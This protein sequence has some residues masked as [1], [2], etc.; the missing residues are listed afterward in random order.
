MFPAFATVVTANSDMPD[1]IKGDFEEARSILDSSPRG[2]AALLRLCVQKLCI[3]LG[4]KGKNIDDDIASLV[5][6]GLDP[7]VQQS[8]D[9]VRVI[10]NE[11]VHPGVIDLNDNRDDAIQL[12]HL[13]NAI[14]D[15]MISHPE[16]VKSLY[17]KLPEAKRKAIEQRNAK[18]TSKKAYTRHF[19]K[20]GQ[21]GF[22]SL[23]LGEIMKNIISA[24]LLLAAVICYGKIPEIDPSKIEVYV[25]PYYN[26]EGP[27]IAVGE[28]SEGLASDSVTDF[29][30]VIR[31]MKESWK[32]LTVEE[33]YV[34]AI[35]LYNRG[36]RDE[37]VYW[38]YTAQLRG[39]A[40]MA[41]IDQSKTG[42]IGAPTFEIL[43]AQNAFFQLVGPYINQYAFGDPETLVK[44]I[45]RAKEDG[46]PDLTSIYPDVAFL[47]KKHREEAISEMLA[48]L[49]GF[50]DYLREDADS[51]RSQ[52]IETGT[53]A[54]FDDLDSKPL[55]EN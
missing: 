52:R 2:A 44:I 16:K 22:L 5:S 9:I 53:A 12:F 14:C 32:E 48:G 45:F 30:E 4:E 25:T 36:Y 19:R 43:H 51:I 26:S 42:S 27:E 55:P 11:S 39:R 33:L 47:P 29:V 34:G 38:F 17:A 35:E 40:F 28:Y 15:Q 7:L 18:A 46:M 24:I 31:R 49:D 1:G 3:H 6:K 50:L 13:L 10:G 41:A 20:S 37:S 8:L 21:A 23:T 54:K